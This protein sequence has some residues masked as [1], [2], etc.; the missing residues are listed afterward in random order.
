MQTS[1]ARPAETFQMLTMLVNTI[2]LSLRCGWCLQC[3]EARRQARFVV[4]VREKFKAPDISK[5]PAC[6]V[7]AS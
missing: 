3:H 4:F 6:R 7:P 2:V 1:P 5:H